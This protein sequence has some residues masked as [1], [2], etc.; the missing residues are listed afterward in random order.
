MLLNN[1]FM[2]LDSKNGVKMREEYHC[3]TIDI[4]QDFFQV[5]HS[6]IFAQVIHI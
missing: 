1:V 4:E 3:I 2:V 5:G 6:P